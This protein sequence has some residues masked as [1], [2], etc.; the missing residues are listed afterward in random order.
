MYCVCVCV[1]VFIEKSITACLFL[2]FSFFLSFF[3]SFL[4]SFFLSFLFSLGCQIFITH[5]PTPTKLCGFQTFRPGQRETITR[6]LCGQSALLVS[7]TG[8]GKSLCYLLPAHMLRSRGEPSMVLVIS[9]LVS[10]M[11]DQV[12]A[13]VVMCFVSACFFSIFP[14]IIITTHTRTYFFFLTLTHNPFKSKR[15]SAFHQ[16]CEARPSTAC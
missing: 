2:Y 8:S 3:L 4:L 9:P 13:A 7:P 12:K 5:P 14:I 11:K 6:I 16:A 10:L 15:W 1:C